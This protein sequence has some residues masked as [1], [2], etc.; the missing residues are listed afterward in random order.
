MESKDADMAKEDLKSQEV[1]ED[2]GIEYTDYE[3]LKALD[4]CQDHDEFVELTIQRLTSPD[5]KENFYGF[6][7]LRRLYK[8]ADFE[9][10]LPKLAKIIIH[11]VENLRSSI[12][13]NSM[14]LVKEIF[15]EDKDL[16]KTLESGEIT[17]YRAFT[18]DLIPVLATRLADD[19]VFLSSLAKTS[20]ELIS[21]H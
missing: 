8:F 13:R 15:S 21:T 1:V 11:G 17:P 12:C 10:Y 14:M 2:A 5:W 3:E 18:I 16:S 19:K 20:F 7:D 6:D 4:E 9:Q